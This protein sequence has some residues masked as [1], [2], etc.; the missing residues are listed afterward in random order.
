MLVSTTNARVDDLMRQIF[1]GASAILG[2]QIVA[3]YIDGSLAYGAFDQ[4]SDIDFIMMLREE[5]NAEQFEA[6]RAMHARMSTSGEPLADQ[7]EG[8]YIPQAALWRFDPANA[9]HPNLER[10]SEE[11]LKW[12]K[13][14]SSWVLHRYILRKCGICL[15]GPAPETV[16]AEV[17]GDELRAASLGS[18]GEW[19]KSILEKE[20]WNTP[21]TAGYHSYIVLTLCRILY[22]V[23]MSD[24]VS[25]KEAVD[26]GIA[27]L[28]A[29]WRAM[30]ES[31][32]EVRQTLDYA[33]MSP[34][35][36]DTKR[37]TYYVADQV[38][39]AIR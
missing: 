39:I 32:W 26:W 38:G 2:D 8:S 5:V 25:K 35:S 36:E 15:Y 9:Y 4:S 14:D 34:H 28:P 3:F 18:F 37:F 12:A 21:E 33:T 27:T 6:L 23:K 30:L 1:A 13:H 10:G 17:S 11:R 7:I 16:V 19:A 22:T 20:V 24:V 29:E 31:A